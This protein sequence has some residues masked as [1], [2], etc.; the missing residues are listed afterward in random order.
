[1]MSDKITQRCKKGF[2]DL[3]DEE[4]R[5]IVTQNKKPC[6]GIFLA[7]GN[8]RLV[9]ALTGIT[10]QSDL[11]YPTYLD[12]VTRY[13]MENL[14]IFFHHGLKNLVFPFIGPSLME[15]EPAYKQV[16][17]PGLLRV[18]FNDDKWL[19]F[20][21]SN[22]IRIKYYGN[23]D[24]LNSENS[25]ADGVQKLENAVSATSLHR[26][27][28]LYFG[29]F[30][31]PSPVSDVMEIY[32]QF[33]YSHG[34]EPDRGEVIACYYGEYL[35]P[36][37]FLITS[38]RLAG[39]GALPP[40]IFGR[41]T[42]MYALVSPGI[43]ALNRCSFREILY[44]FLYGRSHNEPGPKSPADERKEIETLKNFYTTHP[45]TVIGAEKSIGRFRVMGMDMDIKKTGPGL[46]DHEN[47]E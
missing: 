44:D 24:R 18:L 35:A 3:A 22:D 39:L 15:R 34:R 20:Y 46:L 4:I 13:F 25:A 41:E 37:D 45:N 19:Q 40:F 38:S 12:I 8:R 26:S 2:H 14:E 31:S 29:F 32:K 42:R 47:K 28:T 10:P 36:A 23:L 11:F 27:H 7:D 30:S 16:V 9:T 1:M 33:Y 43:F 6:T 17:I 21:K 5:R